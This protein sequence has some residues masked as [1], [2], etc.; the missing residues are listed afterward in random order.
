MMKTSFE[1][2][3]EFRDDQG[4]GASRRLRHAGR[5]PAIL[6]GGK[7]EPRALSLD[8]NKL[9]LALENEKFYSSILQLKVGEQTQ[10]ALLRDVQRHPWKN[11]IVHVDLQ[12]VYEDEMIRLS[13]PLHFVGEAVAPGVKTGG[14]M[15]SHLRNELVVECLPKDL[16]EYLTIDV[17]GMNLNESLHL[18]DIT[19]PAGVISVEAA[20]GK[21]PVVVAV[22]AL[23]AEEA[24]TPV[25]A[26]ATDAAAAPAAAAA[27]DKKPEAKKEEPKKDAKK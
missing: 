8:H 14:G 17:S 23:R 12:R 9:S 25:A 10:T 3:A 16:P 6:Y 4:K 11:Q 15:M 22:H 26:A 18:S 24:E 7:R 1:L 21:N 13:V 20:A 5:V 19:L 27:G 2:I